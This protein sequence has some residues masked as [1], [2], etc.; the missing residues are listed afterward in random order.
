MVGDDLHGPEEVE[1]EAEEQQNDAED[2]AARARRVA[3]AVRPQWVANHDEPAKPS[4]RLQ[5]GH[6]M[7]CMG[8]YSW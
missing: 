1:V 7:G 3:V 6:S 4:S 2:D 8:A 5:F